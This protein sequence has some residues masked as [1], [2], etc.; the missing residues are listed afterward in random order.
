M[1]DGITVVTPMMRDEICRLFGLDP[2]WTGILPNGISEEVFAPEEENCNRVVLREQLGLTKKYVIMY[3]GA[4]RM[5]GGLIESIRAIA[6]L[7]ESHPGIVLFLLGHA[8]EEDMDLLVQTIKENRVE[9]NVIIH[10]PVGFYEVPKYI[11]ASDLGLVPLPN[12]QFWRY[13]QPLKLLEY[14]AMNKPCAVSD[15]PAHRAIVGESKSAIYIP[16]IAPFEIADAIKYAYDHRTELIEWGKEGRLIVMK[17]FI[18]KKVNETLV[19]YLQSVPLSK[20]RTS[21]NTQHALE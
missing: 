18:W 3:H 10:E 20:K 5:N 7:K 14:L 17:K 9:K 21:R 12:I 15:S 8:E 13:Q 19:T 2:S 11:A 6:L 16:R 4:F 1:F